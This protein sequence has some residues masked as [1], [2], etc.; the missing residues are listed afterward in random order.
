MKKYFKYGIFLFILVLASISIFSNRTQ[1]NTEIA[2]VLKSDSYSYLP[3]EAK[4]YIKDVYDETGEIVLT[5]KNKKE[6]TPYLNPK[7]VSYLTL[8]SA[9][10]ANVD[11][12]PETVITDYVP[13]NIQGSSPSTYDLRSV[14]GNSYITPLKNQSSLGICWAFSTVEQ[15]ESYLMVTRGIPYN[16]S[17]EMFSTRQLDYAASDNGINNY[18]NENGYRPL[19]DGGNFHMSSYVLANGLSLAYD[20]YMPFNT[21]KAKKELYEVLNYDNAEYEVDSTIVMP[22]LSDTYTEAELSEYTD[23]VKSYIIEY[24]GAYTGTGSPDSA[25][26][27]KNLDGNYIIGDTGDCLEDDE[28]NGHAM[29]II[30]WDD[31][32]N[33]SYC[34]DGTTHLDVN[35]SG[36]C[37]TGTLV[38]GTGA[39]LLRN[40]W[41]NYT[42]YSYVYMS[43]DSVK[44]DIGFITSLSKMS[45]K[46]WDNNYHNNPWANGGARYSIID[47]VQLKKNISGT[48]KLTKVKFMS[49]SQN[50]KFKISVTSGSNNYSNIVEVTVPMPGIYTIDLS[51]Y[52]VM[53][54]SDSFYITIMSTNGAYI[55]MNTISAFTTNETSTPQVKTDDVS[56]DEIS[57][58]IISFPLYSVTK[59]IPSNAIV[60]YK[61]YN[62]QKDVSNFLTVSNNIVAE[63]NI[64]AYLDIN[65]GIG[66]G[67]YTLVTSYNNNS[68][69]SSIE[70][71][72]ITVTK[73]DGTKVIRNENDV[74]NLGTNNVAK[75]SENGASVTFKY[76]D[77]E[78]LDTT[79]YVTKSYEPAGWLVNGVVKNNN[80]SLIL[81]EDITINYNYT[82]T[83]TSPT[84]PE[85]TRSDYT[86]DG[87][88][89][90]ETGGNLV[91]N[92]N[93]TESIILYA[94]WIPNKPTDF[95]LDSNDVT[96]VV[97]ELH[98][99][100]AAF[101]PEGT[102]DTL[103]YTNFNN[104]IISVNDGLITGLTPGITTITVSLASD[105]TIT[106]TINVEVLSD[107]IIS[108]ALSVENKDTTRIII[109]EEP[110]TTITNF[111]NKLD[112]DNE[113]I[114]IYD[115]NDNLIEDAT[116]VVKTGMKVKLVINNI[117]CDEAIVLIRGDLDED[118]LVDVTDGVVLQ[119]HIL[120]V[121]GARIEDYR[122]YAADI[123]YNPDATIEDMLDVTDG[124]WIDLKILKN[125]DS[126]NH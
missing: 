81:T 98:Q 112:N 3:E 17:T 47:A 101:I 20:S 29:Q 125:I 65:E 103:L 45:T 123:D 126:L 7:Y 83:R 79:E 31:N 67:T 27:A 4:D 11:V 21:S 36:T 66:C 89:D 16:S 107:T 19:G 85:P 74:Y 113:Y 50:G 48:E 53:L 62:G 41:G 110:E 2:K 37:T 42:D 109:G 99:I 49:L 114:R 97:G 63:N 32:Y 59:N 122:V 9:E 75:P 61:L 30:G 93:G 73:P 95:T 115:K 94:H 111:I 12:I 56:I 118:G 117:E 124:N 60:N 54:D 76:Q 26:G 105:N 39:W 33:Y 121:Q 84:F 34:V 35:P 5:E 78:T 40:S 1:V 6:N 44:A 10:K 86:F 69:T 52:N 116:T 92:Y 25:C 8:N 104:E 80:A 102:V 70:I 100:E 23:L 57:S 46:N 82:E 14:N 13:Q 106:K 64:L 24:G 55:L 38:S 15:A 22:S 51:G 43:Y 18:E 120:H 108:T 71:I 119:N 96:I 91:T 68:T 90:S 72:G 58:S 87:W 28:Y 77:G 88:Y